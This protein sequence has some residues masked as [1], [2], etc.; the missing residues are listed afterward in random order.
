MIE[1]IND[2]SVQS[3]SDVFVCDS[4]TTWQCAIVNSK[5][6]DWL[7]QTIR[8]ITKCLEQTHCFITYCVLQCN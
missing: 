2:N 7:T 5:G 3:I 1:S 4:N 8:I 6:I